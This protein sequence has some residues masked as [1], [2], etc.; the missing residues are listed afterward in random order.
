MTTNILLVL[1]G[2]AFAA[3]AVLLVF[4]LVRIHALHRVA[5]GGDT[6]VLLESLSAQNERLE[7]E[8]RAELARARTESA[9]Q[10]QAGR[11]ELATALS[12]FTQELQV[13]LGANAQLQ[14]DRLATLT[15]SNETR[16]EA[17]RATV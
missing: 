15:Q 1:A 5:G 10:A 4:M 2:I 11:G 7:R 8:L 6:R 14:N 9:Q 3:I 16:L 17:V 12:R 13:Q